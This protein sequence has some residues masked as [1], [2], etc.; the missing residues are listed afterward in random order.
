MVSKESIITGAMLILITYTLGLSLVSQAFPATQTSQTL[1]STGTIQIQ[2]TVGLGVYSDSGCTT[3]QTSLSWGTLEPGGSQNVVC[4]IKNEGN[5]PT[6]LTMYA[7]NWSPASAENYLTLNWNYDSNP[8]DID[9]VVQIT[10]TLTVSPDIT[11]ITTFSFDI[12][13]V[14]TS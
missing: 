9:V 14:G 5:T 13:I 3:P 8:I 2:T 12:T 7:S 6:T 11:G 10:F 4:Y 1:S